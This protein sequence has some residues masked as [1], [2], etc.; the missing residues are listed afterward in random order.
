[1]DYSKVFYKNS[2]LT[3]V[4]I[5]LDFREFID[6]PLL[7]NGDI[8]DV[9]IP[10]FPQKGM[11]RLIR[12]EMMNIVADPSG[13]RTEKTTQDG[14][15]QEFASI[16]NNK[17][18]LSNK[19]IVLEVNKYSKYENELSKLIVILKYIMAKT[20]VTAT[21][22]GIRYINLFTDEGIK[23][24]KGYY[25]APVNA[26]ADIKASQAD[27][28]HGIRTMALSEFI[29]DDMHLNFRFGQPNNHYPQPIKKMSFV[30]D[31]DCYCEEPLTGLERIIE[32]LNKGH[33]SIQMLFETTITDKL[34]KVME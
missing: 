34:R 6:S 32:H 28:I 11:Q 31:Y 22:T 30:L 26:F 8:E 17:V 7:F 3:Q 4:I 15:Q 24:Q 14:I 29:I 2:C 13:S 33:D 18:I 12:L 20:A 25:N 23:P 5:R 27:G 21:R 19:F 1:M 10:N 16:D 9:I